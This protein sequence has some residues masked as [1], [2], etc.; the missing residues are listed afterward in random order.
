MNAALL[1]ENVTLWLPVCW[2]GNHGRSELYVR[3][4][5][6]D[7]LPQQGENVQ[8]LA[9]EEEPDGSVNG[10]VKSR[11]WSVSGD[12]NVSFQRVIVDPESYMPDR[13]YPTDTYWWTDRD[14]EFEPYLGRSG[15]KRYVRDDAGSGS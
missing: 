15:W 6:M 12:A 4:V 5:H 8:Y 2:G 10:Y 3:K 1:T 7:F 13:P 11:Y 9:S 14:G